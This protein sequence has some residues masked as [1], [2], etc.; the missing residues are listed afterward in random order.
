[1]M[2]QMMTKNMRKILSQYTTLINVQIGEGKELG[3]IKSLTKVIVVMYTFRS[4][5]SHIRKSSNTK[6]KDCST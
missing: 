4:S 5:F 3:R 2:N 1:M 6:T